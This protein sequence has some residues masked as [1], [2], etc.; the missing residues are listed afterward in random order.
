MAG[1]R[2]LV[3]RCEDPDPR[4]PVLCRRIDEDGLGE[5]D[6]ARERLQTLFRDLPRVGE[7]GE[8]VPGKRHIREDVDDHKAGGRH[9]ATVPLDPVYPSSRMHAIEVSGLR[10]AYGN[11]E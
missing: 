3:R 6:L 1:K 8:L 4:V 10:K 9:A 2:Q 7:D 5:V 11:L